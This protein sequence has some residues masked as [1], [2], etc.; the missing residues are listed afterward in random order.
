[1]E[2][3]VYN[4]SLIPLSKV[5]S[6]SVIDTYEDWGKMRQ[7]LSFW[8]SR[9]LKK[10][11]RES[12]PRTT[13][14]ALLTVN[15]NTRTATLPLDFQ[16]ETF[17]GIIDDRWKKIP[18]KLNN[19][20]VDISNIK[21]LLD[22]EDKCDK[23]NQNK[24]I[25]N[26]LVVTKNT[27]LI[28]LNNNTYEETTLKKLYPNGDYWLE[29]STWVLDIETNNAVPYT[30]KEFIVNFDLK[31]CG[32]LDTSEINL[33][34][35]QTFCPDVYCNYYSTC[36]NNC[37]IDYG[38]YRV[39][40]NTGLIQ[41]DRNY[42][43]DKVYIEYW[44]F[45]PKING[46]YAVPEVAFEALVEWTKFMSIDGKKST[47]N[48]DKIWRWERY[49]TE[50]KNMDKILGRVSLSQ[51]IQSINLIP[52]FDIDY[53]EKWY[54]CFSYPTT[55]ATTATDVCATE[56]VINNT[57]TTV[58]RTAFVLALK[59]D[60]T[61]GQPVAGLSTYQNNILKGAVDIQ[62][63]FL[64]KQILTIKD[65]DFSFDSVTGII[66]ISPNLF[67]ANDSL[68]INYNKNV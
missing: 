11:Q 46:E 66:D 3:T 29:Y 14:T 4:Q 25:C 31:P 21:N 24:N 51:I 49:K 41:F 59:V 61:I 19:K 67:F 68:I 62:W 36:D 7:R 47:A 16:E 44:G 48:S 32:C 6:A 1:M 37:S 5:V 43:F 10:L 22:E 52:K 28:V 8:A 12:L 17:V 30:K 60:G 34:N 27:N 20:L 64:A 57:T 55:A 18:L 38:G 50:R 35:L 15:S 45:M 26:D 40:E 54:G 42:G 33:F 56:T 2:C 13:K 63:I 23:C 58:N 9:G 53:G 65:G 39:F